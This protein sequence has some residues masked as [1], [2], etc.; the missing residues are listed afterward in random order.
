MFLTVSGVW[1]EGVLLVLMLFCLK[2]AILCPT[3][4]EKLW[5]CGLDTPLIRVLAD[6][7]RLS[8]E[9]SCHC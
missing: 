9:S 5:A 6:R 3:D 1:G 8:V 4:T 7:K 2:A